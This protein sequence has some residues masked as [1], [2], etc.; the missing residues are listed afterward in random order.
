VEQATAASHSLETEADTLGRLVG[1]FQI[2]G[3]ATAPAAAGPVRSPS[4]VAAFRK[5]V[6]APVGKFVPVARHAQ[7]A[8]VA[9]DWDEF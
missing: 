9:E 6:Q 3:Q 8:A 1:Q 4:P 2:G 7:A 5:P